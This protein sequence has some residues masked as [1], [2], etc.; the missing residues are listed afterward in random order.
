LAYWRYAVGGECALQAVDQSVAPQARGDFGA[1][2]MQ[3]RFILLGGA[4]VR[5]IY[6]RVSRWHG[7]DP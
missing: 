3:Q 2:E 6:G 7:A 4:D 1:I 5:M